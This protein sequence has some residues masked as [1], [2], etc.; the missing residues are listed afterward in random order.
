[1]KITSKKKIYLI[2]LPILAVF[3]LFEVLS[4]DPGKNIRDTQRIYRIYLW[5]GHRL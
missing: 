2:G 5:P 1:M 3:V 4:A